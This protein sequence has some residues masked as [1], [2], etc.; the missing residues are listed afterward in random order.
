MDDALRNS[1]WNWVLASIEGHGPDATFENWHRVVH[2]LWSDFFKKSVDEI[3]SD[4]RHSVKSWFLTAEWY[5]VY[6]FVE[7]LLPLNTRGH[8]YDPERYAREDRLNATLEREMSGYRS[9]KNQLVEITSPLELQEVDEAA[10]TRTGFEGVAK[11]ITSAIG[12]MG[13]RPTPDY[14]NSIK[15]SISAV[16][17]AAKLLTGGKSGG[18]DNAVAVLEKHHGLHPAF[19]DAL[20]KLYGYTSDADGIRHPILDSKAATSFAEAK[21][22]LVACSAFANFLIESSNPRE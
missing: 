12:L 1:L 18:I 10:T 21:F 15:E 2:V 5:E 6:N 14:R 17:A 4:S 22:M 20:K 3:S 8:G 16:E 11:H 9:V 7:F 13:K 19:K